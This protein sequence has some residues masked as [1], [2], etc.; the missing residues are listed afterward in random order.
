M[1]F[2]GIDDCGDHSDEVGCGIMLPATKN[3]TLEL[4]ITK[5]KCGKSQFTCSPGECISLT[6]IISTLC[7]TKFLLLC[8]NRIDTKILLASH[9][10]INFLDHSIYDIARVFNDPTYSL[11]IIPYMI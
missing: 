6:I 8:Y 1:L 5:Q 9:K 10:N 4:P 2:T 3:I 7:F 11:F